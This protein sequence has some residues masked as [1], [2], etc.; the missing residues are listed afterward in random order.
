[1]RRVANGVLIALFAV[2]LGADL[3]APAPYDKQFRDQPNAPPSRDFP[4]G[5]DELGRDRLSRLLYGAR[6][7]L[8]LAPAAALLATVAAACVGGLAGW[9]GGWPDRFLMA[10][11]DLVLS[12]P[13]LF[14]LITVRAM[15]PLDTP[16][17]VSIG[18]T[19]ALLGCLGWAAAAKAIRAGVQS[20]LRSDFLLQARA[21]GCA[22]ARL[23]F[24]HLL[25]N[26]KPLLGAQ[27]WSAIPAFLIAEA[28]LSLLGLGVAEPMP[29]LGNLLRELEH[30][31]A[32]KSNP[33]I[34]AP[35]VLLAILVVCCHI[36]FERPR[37]VTA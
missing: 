19:F 18:V 33:A 27:F 20:L 31:A 10:S 4:L 3:C 16:P 12:I 2:V 26:L 28:N 29:S 14:L 37:E 17:V 8:L 25:P 22:P 11:T 24:R 13:W 30:V 5:S 32:V 34:L 15:L 9:L 6:V 1:M 35:L 23:L 7:S 36:A 21:A